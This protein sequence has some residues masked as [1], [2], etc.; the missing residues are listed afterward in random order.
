MNKIREAIVAFFLW[1]L[2]RLQGYL[3]WK[4]Y[5]WPTGPRTDEEI[6][7]YHLKCMT[8]IEYAYAY[9]PL[10]KII[11]LLKL[12]KNI[13]DYS[14]EDE[15]GILMLAISRQ[16]PDILKYTLSLG[17]DVYKRDRW[18]LTPLHRA[19]SWHS[20]ECIKILL[21]A[22]ADIHAIGK[23]GQTAL[24]NAAS[25]E[26]IPPDPNSYGYPEI[27]HVLIDAGVDI[28]HQDNDGQTALMLSVNTS[29][30]VF[31]ILL[32][33]KADITLQDNNGMDIMD[34]AVEEI[35]GNANKIQV[36][37]DLGM[38]I[39]T[40]HLHRA[41][42]YGNERTMK[43]LIKLGADVNA[44]DEHGWTPLH[45][46]SANGEHSVIQFLLDNGADVTKKIKISSMSEEN[47]YYFALDIVKLSKE[48][49]ETLL[50]LITPDRIRFLLRAFEYEKTEIVKSL[51][52]AMEIRKSKN[53]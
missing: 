46:A 28:N 17:C 48:T 41:V 33:S 23:D 50:N 7:L 13:L 40:H 14:N 19:A 47:Q 52:D 4:N 12:E 25:G 16:D 37:F 30:E 10:D 38:P 35:H 3:F 27:V 20:S 53:N 26:M 9:E 36:L 39:K 34:Y 42:L 24:H 1:P 8:P 6:R 15:W 44:L 11:E 5:K 32:A 51:T 29:D 22:N 45:I 2:N 21:D 49:K 18:N 31:D 43:K